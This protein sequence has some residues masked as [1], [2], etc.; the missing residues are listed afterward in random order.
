MTGLLELWV[1]CKR[2]S[3]D[4]RYPGYA[5]GSQY[6]K[7]LNVSGNLNMLD[8]HRL[9]DRLLNISR[10]LNIPEFRI[11][12]GNNSKIFLNSIWPETWIPFLALSNIYFLPVFGKSLRNNV[13]F[14]TLSR[15]LPIFPPISLTLFTLV[16]HPR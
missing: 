1:L 5:S 10:V 3:R 4:L 11:C 15:S 14:T 8:F 2:Y 6:N 13:L 12:S 7:I 16:R 9:Y